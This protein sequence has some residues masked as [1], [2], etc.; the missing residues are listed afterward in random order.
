MP[1]PR[2]AVGFIGDKKGVVS[3]NRRK[4]RRKTSPTMF[5]ASL[6]IRHGFPCMF[7]R[8]KQT[9]FG[10][11]MSLPENNCFPASQAALTSLSKSG[12]RSS[13]LNNLTKASGGLVLPFS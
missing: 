8:L 3:R 11:A 9:V 13:S 10:L 1:G 5:P 12:W 2:V 7:W 4:F 6:A